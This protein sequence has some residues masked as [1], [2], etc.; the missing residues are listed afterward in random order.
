MKILITGGAGFIG[1]NLAR[2]ATAVGHEVTVLD[3]LSTGYEDNLDG[4]PVRFIRGSL[5]ERDVVV[6]ACGDQDS[7]VHLGALGSVPRSIANPQR[8]HEVNINGTLN[9]LEAAREV[10]VGHLLFA[11]SSS[12]YGKN[13]A[14]PKH[15]REWVRPMSP[16]AVTKLAGEQYMLAYQQAFGLE[17][18]AFRF[19]NVYGPGQRPGHAYAA[20]IP[21]FLDCLLRDQP[22]PVNGD[23]TQSRDFTYVDT[24][25]SVLLDAVERRVSHDEPVNLAFGTNTNLLELIDKIA[26]ITG[27]SPSVLHRDPR[28]GDVPH[29]QAANAVLQGLFPQVQPVGLEQGIERTWEWLKQ[30]TV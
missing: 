11:S 16:Y 25:C 30:V 20:V 22:L 12:V 28:A 8:T 26:Q 10:G 21:V 5:T 17:T 4:L 18:L 15:E 23:G 14:L 9:V 7:I 27:L 13:P 2:H 3:D 29:S 24:V 19:F 1:S 6:E